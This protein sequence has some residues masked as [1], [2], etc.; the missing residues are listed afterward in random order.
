MLK[1]GKEAYTDHHQ[2]LL[3]RKKSLFAFFPF[4]SF[5]SVIELWQPIKVDLNPKYYGQLNAEIIEKIVEEIENNPNKTIEE[6]S[7]INKLS[8]IALE[9]MDNE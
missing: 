1:N 5:S 7:L 3:F 2:I 9:I 8:N 6:I 4:L